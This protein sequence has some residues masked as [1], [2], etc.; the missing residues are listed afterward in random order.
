MITQYG[1]LAWKASEGGERRILLITSRET[2]RWVIPRGNPIA[3]LSP[4]QA[5][6]QEAW[7]EAGIR[8]ETG[9]VEVGAYRYEK[10]R[11][12]G[13]MVPAE[14]RV[15]AME[16]TEEAD[17]WPEQGERER[18]WFSAADAAAAVDEPELKAILESA[19]REPA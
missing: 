14:V 2:K 10:R 3:G 9:Q 11:L 1:V 15:F 16:V 5:A 18:R 12:G 13:S 4:S 8:G 19:G 17:S 6:A 7:E